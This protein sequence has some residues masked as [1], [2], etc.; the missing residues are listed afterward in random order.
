MCLVPRHSPVQTAPA[1]VWVPLRPTSEECCS[2][3]SSS[4]ALPVL[5]MLEA[6]AATSHL[7]SLLV[8]AML[9]VQETSHPV[10]SDSC[11]YLPV[12][13]IQY[14]VW[15]ALLDTLVPPRTV[16]SRCRQGKIS[17]ML[18][19][20]DSSHQEAPHLLG[21]MTQDCCPSQKLGFMCCGHIT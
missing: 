16:L 15:Q 1:L 12:T 10:L 4:L 21:R 14:L 17:L 5:S 13:R 19:S 7:P 3:V 11:M 20:P 9:V 8:P 2:V 6:C 18:S